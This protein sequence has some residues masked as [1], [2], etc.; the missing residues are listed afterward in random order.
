MEDNQ[1]Q[2]LGSPSS[3]ERDLI[4]METENYDMGKEGT[5]AFHEDPNLEGDSSKWIQV[6]KRIR[7]YKAIINVNR[8]SGNNVQQKLKLVQQAVGDLEDFMGTKLHFYGK[9]QFVMAEF[10]KKERMLQACEVQL[11][12]DNEFK[13]EPLYNRGDDEIKNKTLIVRDLP[14][15]FEKESLKKTLEKLSGNKVETIRTRVTGP[16]LTAH[17]MFENEEAIAKAKDTWSIIFQKDFCRIEPANM[18]GEERAFRNKY[19]LKLANLP[20]GITAYDLLEVF[21]TV[22]AKTCFIPR[23]RDKY[24]RL[25]YA[26]FSFASENDMVKAAE[27]DPFAIKDHRL[28][29]VEC[30]K[31]VCH[32]CGSPNHLVKDC[33]EREKSFLR[34]QKI[35]QYSKVYERYRVPNYRKYMSYNNSY[36]NNNRYN[37]ENYNEDQFIDYSSQ[38]KGSNMNV[39][40]Y[41]EPSLKDIQEIMLTIKNS[42]VDLRKDLVNLAERVTN[43][44]NKDTNQSTS[45]NI[46]KEKHVEISGNQSTPKE[47]NI[48]KNSQGTVMPSGNANP[49]ND[50]GNIR[51]YH[52]LRNFRGRSFSNDYFNPNAGIKRPFS[53]SEEDNSFKPYRLNRNHPIKRVQFNTNIQVDNEMKRNTQNSNQNNSDQGNLSKKV[54]N[55]KT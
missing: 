39:S 24:A 3:H 34:K 42:I 25:R 38:T 51:Q 53:T 22:K 12:E 50:Q 27:G 33:D 52:T 40:N 19:T 18:S 26:F 47:D 15:N 4:E 23:T 1:Q 48:Q 10:G 36:Y 14:L 9:E 54:T 28:F 32:K 11:E 20:F 30:D 35:A 2:I 13:L 46:N 7:R 8:I 55:Y 43:L 31:K 17:V 21:N 6:A 29:W 5:P 16:W 44:E 45:K 37:T 41:G 49:V